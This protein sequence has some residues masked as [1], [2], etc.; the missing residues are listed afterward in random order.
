MYT[1]VAGYLLQSHVNLLLWEPSTAIKRLI[2]SIGNIM[3]NDNTIPTRFTKAAETLLAKATRSDGS[4]RKAAQAA[5]DQMHADGMLWTD[6]IPVGKEH[7]GSKSTATNELRMAIMA[8][9]L[10]GM[11]AKAIKLAGTPTKALSDSDKADKRTASIKLNKYVTD[12]RNAMRMRQD[13]AYKASKSTA[14]TKAPQTPNAPTEASSNNNTKIIELLTQANKKA[15][16]DESP[17]FDVVAL[18][19]L[20]AKALQI[21]NTPVEPSH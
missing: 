13:A 20:L 1:S 6:F 9:R 4:A 10:K 2:N 18:T 14:K 7:D 17:T 15:Q 5:Y 3:N 12:D 19:A 11:G 21:V 16:G 8:A